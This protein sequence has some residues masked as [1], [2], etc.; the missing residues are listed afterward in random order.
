M[1]SRARR[2]FAQNSSSKI[3]SSKVFEHSSPRLKRMG[4]EILP[5]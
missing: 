5:T 3:E 1:C 4:L 2:Y